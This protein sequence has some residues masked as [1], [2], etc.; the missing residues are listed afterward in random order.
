MP[1]TEEINS[2]LRQAV[3]YNQKRTVIIRT[4]ANEEFRKEVE[5]TIQGIV[6]EEGYFKRLMEAA[7][8]M[9]D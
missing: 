2:L 4:T 5:I 6:G 3:V 9:E 1:I 8:Q 7:R